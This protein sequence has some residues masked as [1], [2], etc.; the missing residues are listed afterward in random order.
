MSDEPVGQTGAQKPQGA[1][2]RTVLWLAVVAVAVGFLLRPIT[3]WVSSG[4]I[5][6]TVPHFDGD[7][8]DTEIAD[9]TTANYLWHLGA[10][11]I[12]FLGFSAIGLM[13]IRLIGDLAAGDPF[14]PANVTRLRAIAGLVLLTPF[15]AILLKG[16]SDGIISASQGLSEAETFSFLFSFAW[17]F[18]WLAASVAA[19]AIAEAFAIGTRQRRDLA[20]LV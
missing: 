11:I 3:G 6:V 8:V 7:D 1:G 4:P 19:A 20:G 2:L 13:L 9:P 17:I 15:A 18:T 12:P 10:A 16:V 5:E 14:R